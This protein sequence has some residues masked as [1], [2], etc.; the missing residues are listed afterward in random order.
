MQRSTPERVGT[1][2]SIEFHTHVRVLFSPRSFLHLKGPT[3]K[4]I[5]LLSP[6]L[7]FVRGRL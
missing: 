5:H 7:F 4:R 1:V 6:V 3:R 2:N